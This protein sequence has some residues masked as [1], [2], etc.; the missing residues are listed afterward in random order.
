[1][2]HQK[3]GCAKFFKISLPSGKTGERTVVTPIAPLD[4]WL[5]DQASTFECFNNKSLD[6]VLKSERHIFRLPDGSFPKDLPGAFERALIY[7]NLLTD[8]KGQK[9]SLYSLR[10]TYATLQLLA[11]VPIHIVAK[12]MGTSVYMIERHYS[13]LEVVKR[14]MELFAGTDRLI[15]KHPVSKLIDELL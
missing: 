14:A 12:N 6:E 8:S 11:N 10:H 13:H 15:S 2:S 7:A 3:A 1:M 9:R 5:K 4:M